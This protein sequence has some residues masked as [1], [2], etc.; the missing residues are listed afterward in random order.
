VFYSNVPMFKIFCKA[1][2]QFMYQAIFL[3]RIRVFFS[4]L[5]LFFNLL[6]H[7][8]QQCYHI[9]SY[10]LKALFSYIKNFLQ[11]RSNISIYSL[12]LCSNTV[13]QV[14]YKAMFIH[15]ILWYKAVFQ[16]I[17]QENV[18]EKCSNVH[19]LLQYLNI[20]SHVL[21]QCCNIS[22]YCML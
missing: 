18:L 13:Y 17:R 20:W 6:V 19:T 22:R 15:F 11:Q 7:V 16:K 8:L 4:I 10:T 5:M 12:K 9:S 21:Q 1:V 3:S 14:N 2:L